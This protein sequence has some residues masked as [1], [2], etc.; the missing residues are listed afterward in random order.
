MTAVAPGGIIATSGASASSA[1]MVPVRACLGLVHQKM[2]RGTGPVSQAGLFGGPQSSA[3]SR[4]EHNLDPP[5]GRPG[6]DRG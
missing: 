1:R 5:L 3:A 2:A 4:V 6:E